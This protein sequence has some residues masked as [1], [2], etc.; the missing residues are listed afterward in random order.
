MHPTSIQGVENLTDLGDP[1]EAS[2]LRNLLIRFRDPQQKRVYTFC[3]TTLIALNPHEQMDKIYSPD[4]VKA[5]QHHLVGELPAHIFAIADH[6]LASRRECNVVISGEA[7]SGKTE[8]AKLVLNYLTALSGQ[9]SFIEQQLLEVN[10][11]LEGSR[12]I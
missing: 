1:H 5:Y 11:I 10:P 2:I 12:V 9:H 3:G 8:S 4:F 6:A 7:G